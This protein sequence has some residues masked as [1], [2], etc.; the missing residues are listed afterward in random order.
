LCSWGVGP[1]VNQR[2]H[3]ASGETVRIPRVVTRD[4]STSGNNLEESKAMCRCLCCLLTECVSTPRPGGR[5]KSFRRHCSTATF[6]HGATAEPSP[7]G[8][9]CKSISSRPRVKIPMIFSSGLDVKRVWVGEFF[10][11]SPGVHEYSF[12]I[13]PSRPLHKSIA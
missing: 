11:S 2:N 1:G 7:L 4:T 3:H 13:A 8:A 12:K 6:C 9:G 5:A 10:Q